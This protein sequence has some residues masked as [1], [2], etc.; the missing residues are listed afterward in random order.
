MVR[1]LILLTLLVG[2]GVY[3][4]PAFAYNMFVCSGST[5]PDDCGAEPNLINPDSFNVG[6]IGNHTAVNPFLLIVGV[7]NDGGGLTGP[8][9]SLPSAVNPATGAQ[10]Y[11]LNA[12]TTGGLTGALEG[13]L[14]NNKPGGDCGN[15]V[16]EAYCVSGLL[17][18]NNSNNWSNWANIFDA[19]L[20]VNPGNGTST[21]FH[22]FAYA[23][24]DSINGPGALTNLDFTNIP[25]GSFVVAFGCSTAETPPTACPTTGGNIGSTPF[26]TAGGVG[27]AVPEPSTLLLLGGGLVGLAGI[28]RWKAGR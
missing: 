21:G 24:A 23:I 27:A 22:L 18:G 26:T 15:G 6:V 28:R 19:G 20:G 8:T 9:L 25:V 10:W 13:T 5:N 16:G 14:L 11:G 3:V 17:G 4:A 1:K 2:L 12:A 7:P